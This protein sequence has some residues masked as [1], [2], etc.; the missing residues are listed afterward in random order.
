LANLVEGYYAAP[1]G[2]AAD[3]EATPQQW[4]AYLQ[5]RFTAIERSK[6]CDGRT[7][8]M[9]G[10]R[11]TTPRKA[12]LDTL[13]S[14]YEGDPPLPQINTDYA[15]LFTEV[16]RRARCNY[17][18][19]IVGPMVDRMELQA[20]STRS[21]EDTN[22]DDIAAEIMEETGFDAMFKDLLGFVFGMAEGYGM[23]VPGTEDGPLLTVPEVDGTPVPMIHAIDPRRCYGEPDPVNPIRLRA[24]L[25]YDY[26]PV[27]RANLAHMFLPGRKYTMRQKFGTLA[28][29]WTNMDN[30]EPTEVPD[31]LGGIPIVR[32][33][34][35]H[36]LGEYEPHIDLLDR[37]ID[38]TLRRDVGMWYQALRSRAVMVD[39][40]EDDY[41]E[42]AS[43]VVADQT[44][45]PK[46][47]QDWK[48]LALQAGPGS[49]MKF[50][51][52]TQL[53]ESGQTDFGP[54]INGKTADIQELAS[55]T[56]TPVYLFTPNE[57]QS[58]ALGAGLQR[59]AATSKIKDRRARLQPRLRLLW[60]IAFAMIGQQ[61][62]AKR[63]RFSWG[64]IEF[65]TLIESAEASQQATGTLSTEDRLER[66][67]QMPPDERARNMQRLT[68]DQITTAAAA[69][70]GAAQATPP[71]AQSTTPPGRAT[72]GQQPSNGSRAARPQ[73]AP[74]Q[75]RNGAP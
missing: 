61:E 46:T 47:K 51:K 33:D 11:S 19:S 22:G 2:L 74:T 64:P 34:N 72:N 58:S 15:E 55:V 18:P 43:V 56:S 3:A 48:E 14:Y 8:P 52:E 70:A 20:I 17:A 38:I 7:R 12:W 44:L 45:A 57:A 29:D 1:D 35:F 10:S 50:P 4:F 26:E 9:S 66:C 41:D 37:L 67:W 71:G 31:N 63:L 28:W 60:R 21:D 36:H 75:A 30:P 32:F 53:W 62:R 65:V 5:S 27:T 40:D 13:W 6:Y 68:A 23:V 16:L 59:E 54:F 42:A 73:P 49:F 24:A 25:V 69:A 39:E